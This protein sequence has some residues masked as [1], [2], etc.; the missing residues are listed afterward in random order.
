MY[1][2][3]ILSKNYFVIIWH[4]KTYLSYKKFK[5]KIQDFFLKF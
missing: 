1:L 3:F 5:L 4:V 2:I